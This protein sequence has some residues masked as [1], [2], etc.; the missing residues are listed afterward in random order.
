MDPGELVLVENLISALEQ[1]F[2]WRFAEG[3]NA[4]ARPI[5]I[6]FDPLKVW[7]HPLCYYLGVHALRAATHQTMRIFGFVHHGGVAG[8]ISYFRYIPPEAPGQLI[9][10]GH[11]APPLS[12]PAAQQLPVVFIHGLGCGL[13]VYLRFLR[14]LACS[15]ECFVVELPEISQLGVEAV[16]PPSDMADAIDAMLRAH[17]HARACFV[18]HSY[19]TFVMSWILRA[20]RSLVERVVLL[21]P[22]CFLLAQPDVAFNFLYRQPS[23]LF[24]LAVANFVRWELFSANVLMRHFYWY[25]NVLWLDELP[26]ECVVALSSKDDIANACF[27][28]RYLEN[29]QQRGGQAGRDLKLLWFEGFFHGEIMLSKLAQLQ[30]MEYV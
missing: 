12:P 6:N 21:D 11:A 1:R 26:P 3:F 30:I 29:Y 16:M 10:L 20:R 25:H 4:T 9:A 19:G 17:G 5:R 24:L 28:R 14:R 8:G 27:V 13:A 18:A 7:C 2:G 15:R 23:N 22:V